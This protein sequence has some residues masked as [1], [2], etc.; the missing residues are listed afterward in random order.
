MSTNNN[1]QTKNAGPSSVFGNSGAINHQSQPQPQG[2]AFPGHFQLTEPAAQA[3]AQAQYAQAQA[4]ARA[5]VAH[6]QFQAQ[7]QAQGH[8]QSPSP[9]N[10]VGASILTPGTGSSIKRPPPKAAARPPSSTGLGSTSPLKTMELTP[11][12][13]RK[14]RKLSDKQIP[15]KV[16][17]LLPESALYTQLLEFEC[18]VDSALARKKIDIQESLKN[19]PRVQKTLRIYVFNTF[20][21]QNPLGPEKKESDPPSWSL[22]IIGRLLENGVDPALSSSLYPKFSSFFKRITI[23]LDQNLYPDNHV[24]LWESS[25]AAALNEGFEVKRQGDKE[26]NAIIRLEMNHVPEK[27][28]L[29]PALAD[30]LGIEVETRPRIIAAIWHYV[31]ARKL[32]IPG[33]PSF[34]MCD[35]PLRKVFGEEKVNFGM[36]SQKISQLLSSPQPI[37]LEHRV[38]LSG[39][40]PIGNACYDVLVDVPFS[41]HKE[42]SN[43]LANL[44]KRK[45]VDAC[46]EA[47][48]G[49]LKK[50][51]EHRR[52]RSFFLGFSQSPAEFINTLIASQSKD[53]KL[54]AGD[55]NQSA[56]KE[57]RAEF[58]SQPWVEDAV[59]RYLNRKPAGGSEAPPGST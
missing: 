51:H 45:E 30:V 4:Q 8:L 14:K 59:I 25:R 22:K 32:Q 47:I 19:P 23:Y 41:L 5:Q 2:G 10:N 42:M 39:N 37:Q 26:F 20:S 31:K 28:K 12:A 21:N 11:A 49:A 7:L 3:M 34:F 44:E 57:R 24:I 50:I 13:R 36:V 58:Y 16:A 40:S 29:A 1:N 43:F 18:R 52:R 38:K 27:M 56:E 54:V 9:S 15:D 6:A 35:P 33:D 17:A 55:A 53:L 48:C 46:D